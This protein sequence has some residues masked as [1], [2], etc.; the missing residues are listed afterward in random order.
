MGTEKEELFHLIRRPIQAGSITPVLVAGGTLNLGATDEVTGAAVTISIP[1]HEVHEG[2][3]FEVSY[4]SPDASPIADDGTI[5]F[6]LRTGAEYD[7]LVFGGNSGADAQLEL[8]EG[9]GVVAEGTAMTEHN[10]NRTSVNTAVTVVFRD[11]T[12]AGG[13]LLFDILI[14]GGTGGNASGGSGAVRQGTEWNLAANQ[15]Y[16]I[17]LTNRGGNAQQM[18]LIAQ[19]YEESDA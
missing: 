12:I 18:S 1:H 19:W 4:K 5:A 6:L 14:P 2:E 8:L 7:H 3:M 13:T 15:D 9:V 16:V 10:M 11:P 17:R